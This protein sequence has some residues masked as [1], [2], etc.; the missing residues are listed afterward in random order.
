MNST[1]PT[2]RFSSRVEHYVRHRPGYPT[3][4]VD[5]LKNTCDLAPDHVVADVGCGTGLLAKLF[6]KNGNLV[7]GIEP[8]PEMRAASPAIERLPRQSAGH[9]MF[10]VTIQPFAELFAARQ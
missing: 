3:V 7:Y 9:R 8:N 10:G 2:R 4:L 6:L 5:F 1:D